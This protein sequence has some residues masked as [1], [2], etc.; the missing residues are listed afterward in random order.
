MKIKK[1]GFKFVHPPSLSLIQYSVFCVSTR[2]PQQNG[3]PRF[4]WREL[5]DHVIHLFLLVRPLTIYH[6]FCINYAHKK[7]SRNGIIWLLRQNVPVK[8]SALSVLWLLR[9]HREF[10]G[11]NSI[12]DA[13]EVK[14]LFNWLISIQNTAVRAL[15]FGRTADG[16][17][18]E[19]ILMIA[20]TN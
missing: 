16:L 3:K 17:W 20:K 13:V 12:L 2:F 1:E 6:A 9:L 10:S 15:G 11:G 18:C 14:K 19:Q 4:K 5:K 8:I 7:M